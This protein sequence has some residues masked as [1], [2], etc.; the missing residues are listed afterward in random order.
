MGLM[1]GIMKGI[2]Q[3][4]YP[5]MKEKQAA[6]AGSPSSQVA[7]VS[8]GIDPN[9]SGI[10]VNT[11]GAPWGNFATINTNPF[12]NYWQGNTFVVPGWLNWTSPA[13]PA[14]PTAAPPAVPPVTPP[15][16]PP[17]QNGGGLLP[18]GVADLPVRYPQQLYQGQ[19]RGGYRGGGGA[20]SASAG[21]RTR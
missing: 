6:L 20:S 5:I 21:M 1:A 15:A 10:G 8:T 11:A 9:W 2:A 16:T 12:E 19:V 4:A 3:Q 18:N 14:P 7:P 13:L 17:A